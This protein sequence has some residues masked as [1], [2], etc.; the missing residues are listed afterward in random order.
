[1]SYSLAQKKQLSLPILPQDS[2]PKIRH[3]HCFLWNY[4]H[5]SYTLYFIGEERPNEEI[6]GFQ[7]NV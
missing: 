3:F 4:H 2:R 6:S 1:M 5:F 7:G